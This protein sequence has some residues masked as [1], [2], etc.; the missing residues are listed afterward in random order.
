MAKIICFEG[1]HG[2]GKGTLINALLEEIEQNYIGRSA[3]I[4]DSEFSEFEQVKGRIR[5]GNLSNRDEIITTVADVRAQI[6][7]DHI[8]PQLEH[9]D[10]ALLDRSYYTSAVWQSDSVQSMYSVIAENERRGIPRAD[11][12]FI[13]S[14]PIRVIKERLILRRR[15]DLSE[16]DFTRIAEN[17][18]K[19][20]DLAEHCDECVLFDTIG[21]P[22]VLA[23]RVYN[24]IIANNAL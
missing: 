4:R 6:Y 22:R 2:S 11:L 3:V 14:A 13:L 5:S 19:Y 24:L 23:K 17:R 9:L 16:H 7:L 15:N 1:V 21:E 12:T 8:D 18:L 20:L 10:L